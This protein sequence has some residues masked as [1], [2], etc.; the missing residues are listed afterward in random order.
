[1]DGGI[2]ESSSVSPDRAMLLCQE[3]AMRSGVTGMQCPLALTCRI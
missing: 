1:M 2:S 3:F